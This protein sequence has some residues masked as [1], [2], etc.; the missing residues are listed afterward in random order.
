MPGVSNQDL[1]VFVLCFVCI[2]MTRCATVSVVYLPLT[3]GTVTVH[4][5]PKQ[6]W[7][8]STLR[9]DKHVTTRAHTLKLPAHRDRR[10]E[11]ERE[12]RASEWRGYNSFWR[13]LAFGQRGWEDGGRSGSGIWYT[14]EKVNAALIGIRKRQKRKRS[15]HQLPLKSSSPARASWMRFSR[16][17]DKPHWLDIFP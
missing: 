4:L 13:A 3:G 14:A 2:Q 10:D 15:I 12:R 17:T 9:S 8:S 5:T 1:F 11:R 7:T 16:V 6:A